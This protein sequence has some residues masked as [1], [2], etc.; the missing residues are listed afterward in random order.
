MH[1]G[2]D[3]GR[4]RGYA[5]ITM[6]VVGAAG[7]RPGSRTAANPASPRRSPVPGAVARFVIG[8]LFAALLIGVGTFV[9]VTRDAEQEA[10]RHAS[11]ITQVEGHGIVEPLLSDA[12][13]REDAGARAGLDTVVHQRILSASVVRV[14]IWTADGMIVYSDEPRLIGQRFQLD[15][16]EQAALMSGSADSGISDLS[17][18][19]N[20]YERPFGKLLQVY[21][22]VHTSGGTP[23][24]FETYQRYESITQYQQTVW[25]SFLPVLISG[26][27][28]LLVV[29]IPLAYRLAH[30]LSTAVADR[31]RLLEQAI[32]AS[33]QERRR[34]ARDLHDGVVQNLAGTSYSL[35]A[36][37]RRLR[38]D[39][40]GDAATADG[41]EQAVAETRQAMADLRT[42]I[43]EI[44]PPNLLAEGIDNAIRD[45][46]EPLQRKGIDTRLVAPSSSRLGDEATGLLC[47]VAQEALRNA[48]NHAGAEHIEV[49]LAELEGT[50][51]LEIADDGR[52]FSDAD[53]ER[54]RGQGH[55]GLSLLADLVAGSGGSL[56]VTSQPGE[57]TTVRVEIPA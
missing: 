2:C 36:L 35:S 40:G 55:V 54:R 4:S 28:I 41:I 47:R 48:G 33:E 56:T 12:L 39:P 22:P 44:A 30:R 25:A 31:E 6:T 9:V 29:Q 14:K 49:R 16:P 42:L 24:L 52:G 32:G 13:I 51:S 10:I 5:A 26:L 3:T 19:E 11:D 7:S 15:E 27:V 8:G 18:P 17:D 1:T 57:G 37:V 21:F 23:L 38:R 50:V 43:V 34:I 46:L 45:L 53:L 20:Q